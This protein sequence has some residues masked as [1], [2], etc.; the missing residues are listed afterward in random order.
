MSNP[1]HYLF[2][3][4]NYNTSRIRKY[5]SRE[6]A[7]IYL[8][9]IVF[10]YTMPF[11]AVGIHSINSQTPKVLFYGVVLAYGFL[12]FYLNKRYFENKSTYVNIMNRYKRGNK[13]A[14]A[15]GRVVAWV[16]LITSLAVFLLILNSL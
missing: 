2:Y 10:F 15:I 5:N 4:L 12:V 9:V 8:S 7:I 1:Y 13:T 11:V 14:V 6:A 3:Y 16:V